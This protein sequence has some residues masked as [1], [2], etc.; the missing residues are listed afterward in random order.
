MTRHYVPLRGVLI[1]KHSIMI[2]KILQTFNAHDAYI[3]MFLR[4]IVYQAELLRTATTTLASVAS[5]GR[6]VLCGAF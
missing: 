3:K 5:R 6:W 1:H 2:Q 4:F